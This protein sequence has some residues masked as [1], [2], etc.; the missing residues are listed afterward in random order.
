MSKAPPNNDVQLDAW[1]AETGLDRA[2]TISPE[3]V[4]GAFDKAR[5]GAKRLRRPQSIWLELAGVY[6]IA[7]RHEKNE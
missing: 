4:R 7:R 2:M 3:G 1:L 6:R 5:A